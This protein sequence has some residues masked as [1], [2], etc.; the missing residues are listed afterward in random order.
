MRII[1]TTL[2]IQVILC[3][4]AIANSNL[5]DEDV[6]QIIEF[7]TS[8]PRKTWISSGIIH[9]NHEEYQAPATI[10]KPDEIDNRIKQRISEY[11]ATPNKIQRSEKLQ[12]MKLEAIPFNTRYEL[13]NEYIMNSKEIVKYDGSR[14]Y[15]EINAGSRVD[16]VQPAAD[17]AENYYARK[18]DMARNKTRI[19]VWDG[20]KYT[21]YY[22]PG[23]MAII[24]DT[25]SGVNGPLTA[26]VI[27]WGYGRYSL[28]NLRNAQL[29]A[30]EIESEDGMEIHLIIVNEDKHEIFI[31]DPAKDFAVKS[32]NLTIEND[33]MSVHN[34]S[35]Y[36]LVGK[37][38]CPSNIIIEEYDITAQPARLISQDIWNFT[39]ISNGTLTVD[40]FNVDYEYDALIE[41]HSLGGKPLQYRF[42]PP[43]DP[44]VSE[45]ETEKL[46][47]SRLEIENSLILAENHNCATISL[48]YVCE[49]LGYNLSWSDLSQLIQGKDNSTNMLD[50]QQFINGFGINN[51]AIKT[52]LNTLK[53]L[54]DCEVILHLPLQ[55]HY[56]VL[57][58]IDDKYVRLIDLDQN[59]FFYRNSIEH[60]SKIWDGTA[61]LVKNK[62][63]EENIAFAKIN[64]NQLQNI[65][66]AADCESCT[67]HEQ[68]YKDEPC[69]SGGGCG[70]S[71]TIYYERY[72]CESASSGSCEEYDMIGSESQK[73]DESDNSCT[74]V[75]AWIPSWMDACS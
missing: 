69:Y 26:G 64:T 53:N 31:L 23:N 44:T 39:S 15:W 74:G 42:A 25:P 46:L 75:G 3:G 7:L 13:Q 68:S 35:N 58:N 4:A 54:S 5:E 62:P 40:N 45:K 63:I 22:K 61:L 29:S 14:F 60:F 12:R 18:F 37:S 73:C 67:D 49:K 16:S 52:D 72:R 17:L 36:Q 48:K 10:A 30:T 51:V 11:R 43:Q 32:Y 21:K 28:E 6:T 34:Y 70:S 1:V 47:Q 19:F 71:H 27:P 50:M 57:G 33:S 41:D 9:A 56:V 66:G 55:N 65:I 8:Q 20:D 24:T 2:L 38:W 59:K